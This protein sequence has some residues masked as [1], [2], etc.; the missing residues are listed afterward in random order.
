M[1]KIK[2]YSF[3]TK[4]KEHLALWKWNEKPQIL[5]FDA[6]CGFGSSSPVTRRSSFLTQSHKVCGHNTED[7]RSCLKTPK[8]TK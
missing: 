7:F 1:C 5:V 6:G 2:T 4:R 3:I 8:L